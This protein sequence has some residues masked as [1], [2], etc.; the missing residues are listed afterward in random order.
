MS[1]K[2]DFV[3]SRGLSKRIFHAVPDLAW[4]LYAISARPRH[5]RNLV[6]PDFA[7]TA[8]F[9]SLKV[10]TAFGNQAAVLGLSFRDLE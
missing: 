3:H 2:L 6:T 1:R 8:A 4:N 7:R 5:E 9:A 10:R